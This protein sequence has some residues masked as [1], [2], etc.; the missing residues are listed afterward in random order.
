MLLQ[1]LYK[2]ANV[3]IR[4]RLTALT[5]PIK[6]KKLVSLGLELLV[7]EVYATVYFQ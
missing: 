3:K 1:F 5:I 6:R 4:A 2:K 7:W